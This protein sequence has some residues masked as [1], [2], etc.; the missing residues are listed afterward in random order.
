[1][2]YKPAVQLGYC[3]F[4]KITP[5][6]IQSV[7]LDFEILLSNGDPL[8][9]LSWNFPFLCFNATI[10]KETCKLVKCKSIQVCQM[11]A[12]YLAVH[13]VRLLHYQQENKLGQSCTAPSLIF[14][15]DFSLGLP[16]YARDHWIQ[17][18]V[19]RT[20]LWNIL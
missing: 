9:H 4:S 20:V 12:N 7:L 11:F 6:Y 10:H 19:K 13:F 2:P 8:A 18:Q 15:A 16:A 3:H 17:N 1:M 5:L 14:T